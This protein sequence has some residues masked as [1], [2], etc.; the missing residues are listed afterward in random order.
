MNNPWIGPNKIPPLK[1][2]MDLR[3]MAMKGCSAFHKAP[4]SL[5][6]H[7]QII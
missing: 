1:A 4:A 3:A 7:H 5:E 2:E 6:P